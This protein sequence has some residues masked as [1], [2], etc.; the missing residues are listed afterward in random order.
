[1]FVVIKNI[2]HAGL[3]F[4]GGPCWYEGIYCHCL[5]FKLDNLKYLEQLSI[6]KEAIVQYKRRNRMPVELLTLI[7]LWCGSP[8]SSTYRSNSYQE[9]GGAI[10]SVAQ[11]K[12]CRVD[13]R[14]CM[15]KEIDKN[16]P[17][18][19]QEAFNIAADVCTTQTP[20]PGKD[21]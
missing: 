21:N 13:L 10:V 5:K 20:Q 16:S 14:S 1:M 7:A 2:Q 18:I 19:A 17:M 3:S 15:K 9:Y 8:V 12:Q 11:V 4:K 6:K